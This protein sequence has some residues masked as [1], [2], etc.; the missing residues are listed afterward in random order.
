MNYAS[1]STAAAPIEREESIKILAVDDDPDNLLALQA[2]LEP[3]GQHL[4]LAGNGVEALKLCLENDFA[5]ILL[6]VR[7]PEL[8]GFETAQLIRQRRRSSR[9]PILFLTAYRSDE[10]L[11]RGY[12]MGA[13][14]FLFK[15]IVPEILQSKVN[16]FVELSRR[17]QMLRRQ[18]EAL[19]RTER[20]FR[21]VLEAAPDAM[22]ITNPSGI[23]ELANSRADTLFAM[24]RESLLGQSIQSLIP[25]WEGPRSDTEDADESSPPQVRLTAVRDDGSKFPVDVRT[26]P[27][28]TADGVLFTTAVRDVTDQ[29]L[30][31]ERIQRINAELERRVE[32]R[33][34]A[35]TRSNEALRQFTW[36]ASHDLQEPIRTV[37]TYAGLLT[38]AADGKLAPREAKLL[39]TIHEHSHRL[40][41]L[42]DALRQYIRVGET[43]EDWAVV[44]CRTLVE[45]AIS[46]LG[47]M[48]ESSGATITCAP[49]PSIRSIDVLLIQV[50]QNLIANAI[51]YRSAQPPEIRISAVSNADGCTFAV[52]DNGVG[53]DPEYFE[54]IFGVFRRLQADGG[55]G[56]GLG[57]AICKAAVQ[58]VGGRIWVE[59]SLGHGSTFFCFVPQP[60]PDDR[61]SDTAD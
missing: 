51:K 5:A 9:T 58:R 48:V 2:I 60:P 24:P 41:R 28:T 54:Y 7:M 36:A 47:S 20:K 61:V 15:P 13:V 17:E 3:L 31:E 43:N 12:D 18:T 26:S 44:D 49:L 8:D 32:E 45:T 37:V 57:L 23:I 46:N 22:V 16:V 4:L 21:T 29:V 33:T 40:H 39:A 10:Q 42:F 34:A 25:A 30:A 52:V 14:D 55:G 11:F 6:D 53:I 38:E 27:F 35:L 1:L 56:T 19:S 50:F 59:S